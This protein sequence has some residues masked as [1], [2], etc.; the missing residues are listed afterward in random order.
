MFIYI[1][2]SKEYKDGLIIFNFSLILINMLLYY[3]IISGRLVVI[4]V[5]SSLSSSSSLFIVIRIKNKSFFLLYLIFIW[6]D[7]F[8]DGLT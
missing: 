2:V 1:Y 7:Q 3:I 8:E 6:M 5:N 4:V